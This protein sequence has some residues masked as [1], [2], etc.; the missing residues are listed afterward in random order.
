MK[1]YERLL[2]MG[3][4]THDDVVSLTGN[5]N[6]AGSL[7]TSY[8]QK[9]YIQKV[10]RNLYIAINLADGWPAVSKFQIAGRITPTAY[11]S[12]H[13]AFDY[14]GLANQVSYHVQVSS[15]TPF[16]SFYFDDI[17]YNYIASHIKIGVITDRRGVRVTGIERTVVDG[18]NDIK[19]VMG[20]EELLRCLQLVESVC[21]ETLLACLAAYGKQA[22]YQKTGYILRYF[23]SD[24][25][26]SESFFAECASYINKSTRYLTESREGIYHPEWRLVAPADLSEVTRKFGYEITEY[27]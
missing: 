17:F 25:N 9:G 11:V 13:A 27:I 12:Y 8:Q 20:L 16:D 14:Y 4:F 23:Q 7:L 3:Y 6:T 21:E 19:R 26:L 15:E 18:I 10:R 22:L 5:Y 2:E 24:W 1:Y